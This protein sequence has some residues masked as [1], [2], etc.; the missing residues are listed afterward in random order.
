MCL[1]DKI[2]HP[3][4]GTLTELQPLVRVINSG[5]GWAFT[6][7]PSQEPGIY[8]LSIQP[9]PTT[10]FEKHRPLCVRQSST[11]WNGTVVERREARMTCPECDQEM[12]IINQNPGFQVNVCVNQQCKEFDRPAVG[13]NERY[14]DYILP[15]KVNR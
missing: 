13:R 8:D 3:K 6:R 12:D 4:M 11:A 5:S 15:E 7:F 2:E 14:E 10:K 9:I 1:T